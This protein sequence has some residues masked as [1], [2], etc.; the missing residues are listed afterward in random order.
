MMTKIAQCTIN[1]VRVSELSFDGT[2]LR[3]T[4]VLLANDAVVGGYQAIM[5]NTPE[6]VTRLQKLV[7]AVE[8]S[9]AA[10]LGEAETVAEVEERDSKRRP[11]FDL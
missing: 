8:N 3:G 6:V 10:G 9:L 4:V 11:L 2:V 5:P 7:E 1:E